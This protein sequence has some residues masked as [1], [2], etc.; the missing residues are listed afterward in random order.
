M[1]RNYL[2]IAWRNLFRNRG[3]AVT[4]LL[5][6]TVGITCTILILL[7][8]RDELTYNKF[9][10][11]YQNIYQVIANRQFNNQMFTDRNMAFPLAKSLEN[12]HPQIKNTVMTSYDESHVLQQ[13]ET[14]LTQSGYTVS[15]HFF[16]M[17]SW[18][19]L[20][21]NA[22]SAISRPS[23]IVLTAASAK[24]LFGN[25]DPINKVLKID[26]DENLT[27]TAV[28]A[29]I[30][31]N[32]TFEFDYLRNWNYDA[33]SAREAMTEWTSSSWQVFVQTVP[34]ANMALV[35][36]QINT[37]KK[38]NS[39]HGDKESTYFTFPMSNW[40]LYSDFRD[41]KNVG[42]M[43]E[44]IRLFSIIAVIILVIACVNFM[45]L[46]T[47]RSE[48]RAREVG[49]RKT[50][51]SGKR[52][53]VLQFFVESVIL[54][55]I[56][57]LFSLLAV[58]LLLPAFNRLVDKQLFIDVRQPVFWAAGILIILFTGIVAGSYPALYLSSF[59]PVKVLKG[60]IL[61]GKKAAL[62]RQALVVVQFVVSILLIS[63]TVIVYQQ[64]QH[65][66]NRPTGYNPNNLLML[67]A[68]PEINA[69]FT[70]IKQ[71]L[72][73][74]GA[75]EAVTRTGD[76]ITGIQ[77]RQGA[78]DWTGKPANTNLIVGGLSTD[79]DY[80]KTFHIKILAGKDFAGT[81]ADS[82]SMLLNKAA[83]ETMQLKDPVGMQMRMGGREFTVI[84]ITDNVISESPFSPV[85]P[86][87][88]LFDPDARSVA[89]R[90]KQGIA[91]PPALSSI[92]SIFKKYNPAFPFD[93]QFV[94][95]EFEKKF[96]NEKLISQLTN[97]FAGLA[98]FICC[99]GLAG[100]AS[101]TIEKR[102]REIGIRKIL[103]A[104]VQQLLLLLSKEF[105]YLVAI[106]LV[107]A[108]P[109][110]W[111]TMSNWLNNYEYHTTISVWLFVGVAAMVLLL[112]LLIV[113]LN[114]I[115]A[116]LSNPVNNLRQ[117]A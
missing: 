92:E 58:T 8:V 91:L 56:A 29:D 53:L 46:S 43:I 79:V 104:T 93:Y 101:F 71:S 49:I 54:A 57:F 76:A 103:G 36:K 106:A 107:V 87:L 90:L 11:N 47:A 39:P 51:G 40:R 32:S 18:Q 64:L 37:I 55:V 50:M 98:I 42:G 85:N 100:L 102:I 78:P 5:G 24:A 63:A 116:A 48:R 95:Q 84:G 65:V 61:T 115:R 88:V 97:I 25:A 9:H 4:N 26:N 72:L 28:L 17:F 99:L 75:V 80:A 110:T 105:L 23:S 117:R 94:D 33:P 60:A 83:V 12:S 10:T 109:L 1:F 22:Q 44:Y 41:G 96:L 13:G 15:E 62:P 114:T 38:K 14:K 70:V 45:N 74:T 112:A 81:P 67:P 89:I 3:F 20:K 66:R 82:A 52:E 68:T 108:L 21:G 16:D 27:V 2:K 59:N 113:C 34:D 30:P 31:G 73:N 7:W 77:W 69:Q 19:F 35:Q 86:L 111:W 6:L